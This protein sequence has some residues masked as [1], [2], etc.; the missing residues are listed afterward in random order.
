MIICLLKPLADKQEIRVIGKPPAQ[1]KP[2]D[3]FS[4]HYLN[5]YARKPFMETL[6]N[7]GFDVVMDKMVEVGGYFGKYE[8]IIARRKKN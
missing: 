2:D 3:E 8:L 7:L 1:T 5:T 4:E 6:N